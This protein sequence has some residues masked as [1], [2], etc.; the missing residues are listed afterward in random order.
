MTLSSSPV[1]WVI[2]NVDTGESFVGQFPLRA[3]VTWSSG[4]E[5]AALRPH[6]SQDEIIQWAGGRGE[7]V[8]FTATF[9]ARNNDENQLVSDLYERLRGL[10]EKD[11]QLGRAPVCLFQ[12]AKNFRSL[13]CLVESVEAVLGQATS[14]GFPR[15]IDASVTLRKYT[16]FRHAVLDPTRPVSDTRTH[17]VSAAERSY[18]AIAAREYGN[19]LLGDRLRKRHPQF[20]LAPAPGD[21][22]FLPRRSTI[23]GEAVAPE[24]HAFSRNRADAQEV[25]RNAIVARA[26]ETLKV[27]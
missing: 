21:K 25:V 9:Y 20:P 27:S 24:F 17:T 14:T 7:T 13:F 2:T 5:I 3:G 16:T 26:S 19:P 22:L 11:P 8:S 1:D 10:A 23:V 18:E 6:S 15:S 4:A 12:F